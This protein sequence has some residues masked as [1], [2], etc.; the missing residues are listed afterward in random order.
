C[1]G[2]A[3]ALPYLND[4]FDIIFSDNVLEHLPNPRSVFTEVG[5]VLK[6][7]GFFLVKTPNRY[8]YVTLI[9]RMTST[10]FHR[11]F[12]SLRGRQERDTFPTM[13]AANTPGMI[14]QLAST[15]RLRVE[16]LLLLEGRPEYCRI[17]PLMYLVG[18]AYERLVNAILALKRFRLVLIGVIEK[19]KPIS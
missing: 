11:W 9:S 16:K 8:H 6:P 17:H 14:E 10:S 5:R 12:N 1:R 13:Y 4:S 7:G 19:D 15:A 3:E 18:A 2:M